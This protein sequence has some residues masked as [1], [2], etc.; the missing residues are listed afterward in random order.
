MQF[1]CR[2]VITV[3]QDA[4]FLEV[5]RAEMERVIVEILSI[6]VYD[7]DDV[8]LEQCEVTQNDN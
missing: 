7:I 2:L 3:D 8:V 4:N 1:E 5:D 6:A